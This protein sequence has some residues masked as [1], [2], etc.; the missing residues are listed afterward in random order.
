MFTTRK[1]YDDISLIELAEPADF[2]FGFVR[3]ICLP[4][5]ITSKSVDD[6]YSLVGWSLLKREVIK[7]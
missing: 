6:K 3:P 2:L 7:F 4:P 1:K 5:S